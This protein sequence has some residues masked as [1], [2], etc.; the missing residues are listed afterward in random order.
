MGLELASLCGRCGGPARKLS[1]SGEAEGIG[2]KES[3]NGNITAEDEPVISRGL[4]EMMGVELF[5]ECFLREIGRVGK[6]QGLAMNCFLV[7]TG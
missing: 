1:M 3:P 7:S 6:D 4:M 5:E 2:I